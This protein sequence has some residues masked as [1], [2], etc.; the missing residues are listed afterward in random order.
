MRRGLAD[1]I[2]L[3][4]ALVMAGK[5]FAGGGPTEQKVDK[6]SELLPEE[7]PLRV[8]DSGMRF[9]SRAGDKLWHALHDLGIEASLKGLT[10]LDVGASTGGFT[11]CALE[12]GAAHVVSLDVGVGQL[13]WE[14]RTDARVTCLER[15]DLR[16]FVRAEHPAIDMVVAD[17]SFNSLARLAPGLRAAAPRPGTRF[18]LL[19]KPQFE[20]PRAAVPDGGVVEDDVLRARAAASVTKALR[21][22][23]IVVTATLDAKVAGRTGNREIFLYG[24]AEGEP[25]VSA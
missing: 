5:V 6:P 20:L 16:V 17:V 22:V 13:A 14:L 18:L 25:Q 23:G 4:R 12:L 15:T 21:A 10:I 11:Q 2:E 1:R 8:K 3:A 9:V 24:T 7:T 19:V